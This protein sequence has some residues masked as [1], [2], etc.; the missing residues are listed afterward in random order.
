MSSK[1][2][3]LFCVVN[4]DPPMRGFTVQINPQHNVHNLEELIKLALK[5]ALDRVKS[6]NITLWKVAIN[7]KY[8]EVYLSDMECS[9]KVSLFP[10]SRIS[11]VFNSVMPNDVVQVVVELHRE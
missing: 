4:G 2:L 8:P 1:L 3:T 9:K 6:T 10:S 11:D 5:P 7:E